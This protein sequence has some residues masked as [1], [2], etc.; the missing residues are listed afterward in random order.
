MLL[1]AAALRWIDGRLMATAGAKVRATAT[2]KEGS[3]VAAGVC[4]L[5]GWGSTLAMATAGVIMAAVGRGMDLACAAPGAMLRAAV[6][7]LEDRDAAVGLAVMVAWNLPLLQL[8]CPSPMLQT[9]K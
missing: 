2:R 6:V 4:R 1:T 7:L 3:L 9:R 8:P 5:M